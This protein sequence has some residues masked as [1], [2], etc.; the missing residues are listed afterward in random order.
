MKTLVRN[1]LLVAVMFGTYTSY[2]NETLEVITTI[3]TIKKGNHISVSDSSGDV[4]YSSRI[5]YDGNIANLFDFTQLED[6]IYTIEVNKDFIIEVN[7]IQVKDGVVVF[8]KD[9]KEK[10]FKPVFRVENSKVIISKL[11]F[12]SNKMIVELYYENEL[13]YTDTVKGKE[14]LNGVYKLDETLHGDY[15]AII[16]SNDRVYVENFRI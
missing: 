8:L 4:V 13:I 14:I 16:R 12:D 6:G 10:I 1:I 7:S 2:A 15:S 11:G 3:N 5:N 9:L